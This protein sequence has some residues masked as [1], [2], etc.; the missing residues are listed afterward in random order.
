MPENRPLLRMLLS[1]IRKPDM[2]LKWEKKKKKGAI[3][4]EAEVI[5]SITES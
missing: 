3:T 1:S 2:F 4:G 5:S